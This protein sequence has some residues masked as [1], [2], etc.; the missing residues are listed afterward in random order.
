MIFRSIATTLALSMGVHATLVSRDTSVIVGLLTSIFDAMSDADN[1]VLEYQGGDPTAL[2]E[3]AV[4]L[5]SVI[6]GSIAPAEVMAPLTLEDVIEI[7]DISQ[8]VTAIGSQF[9]DHL[10]AAAPVVAANGL[11]ERAYEYSINLGQVSNDFFTTTKSKFPPESQEHAT[12][13]ID[14]TNERFVKA[15]SALAPDA[16]VNQVEPPAFDEP[17]APSTPT[18]SLP[19]GVPGKNGTRAGRPVI[20]VPGSDGSMVATSGLLLFIAAALSSL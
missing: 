1:H 19:T 6:N 10:A 17:T 18:W 4:N 14:D 3:S 8:Q 2:R 16:C 7:A 15:Q 9:L 13:E 5:Y 20:P 11:C 12:E